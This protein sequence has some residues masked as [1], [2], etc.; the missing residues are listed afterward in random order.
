MLLHPSARS[1]LHLAQ[2][3]IDVSWTFRPPT[4]DP[5]LR[6][7]SGR[8]VKYPCYQRISWARVTLRWRG[9]RPGGDLN[10]YG[11][12]ALWGFNSVTGRL[13]PVCRAATAVPGP[14]YHL[15]LVMHRPG[16]AENSELFTE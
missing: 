10:P 8:G 4:V 7:C 5:A 3:M 1:R 13:I 16:R 11:S 2:T 6:R 9:S 15:L 14:S 12:L